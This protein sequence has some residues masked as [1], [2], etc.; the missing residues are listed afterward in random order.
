D[1]LNHFEGIGKKALTERIADQKIR[2]RQQMQSARMFVAIFLQ[3]AE[4]IRVAQFRP[5]LLENVPIFLR[6]VRT[7]LAG[8]V[9]LQIC[10]HSVVV[11]QRVVYVEQED[12]SRRR[13]IAFVHCLITGKPTPLITQMSRVCH[14]KMQRHTMYACSAFATTTTTA[15]V[16]SPNSAW[17]LT[18]AGEHR[19]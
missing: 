13:T 19:D 9:A 12:D 17:S 18:E 11:Q 10:C 16:R 15:A 6:S 2:H 1:V 4:I 8:K 5:Q 14:G 7:D 3:S